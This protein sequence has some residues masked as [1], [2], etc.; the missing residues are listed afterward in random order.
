MGIRFLEGGSRL[1]HFFVVHGFSYFVTDDGSS[2]ARSPFH[3]YFAFASFLV[4]IPVGAGGVC[5]AR[6]PEK[7]LLC[8]V[9]S[10]YLAEDR[11]E[12]LEK[13]PQENQQQQEAD[14]GENIPRKSICFLLFLQS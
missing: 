5:S 7:F 13:E 8:F 11:P 9:Q 14:D 6:L 3:S 10:P 1:F 4:S 2:I 12:H